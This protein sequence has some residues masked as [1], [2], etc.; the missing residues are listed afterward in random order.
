MEQAQDESRP[1]PMLRGTGEMWG[2]WRDAGPFA[3]RGVALHAPPML[4]GAALAD[5]VPLRSPLAAA[6]RQ[7]ES[8]PS[9][10]RR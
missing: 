2:T 9:A 10:P 1:A 5:R 7:W 6:P 4:L 3:V 8:S